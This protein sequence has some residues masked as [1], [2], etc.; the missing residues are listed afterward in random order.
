LTIYTYKMAQPLKLDI[1]SLIETNPITKLS[2]DYN[3]KLLTKIK[4]NFTDME[5]QLFLSSFYCYL[6]YHPTND[7]I[8]DLDN[9]WKWLGFNKK[10]NSERILEKHFKIDIDYKIL[11]PQVGEASLW[12]GHNK[13]TVLLTIHTF[14]LFCLLAETQKAKELHS[15]FIKLEELLHEVLEEEAKELKA[16]LLCIEQ[17]KLYEKQKAVEQTLI[18]QFPLNTECVYFGK[19]DNTNETNELLIK[20]G[21]TNNLSNRILEHRKNYDNFILL[22][23]FKVQNKVE[24]ENCI[25]CHP[26]IKKQLRNIQV[27]GKNKTEIIAYNNGNFTIDKLTKYIKEIIQEKMYS[28][29]NYNNL[30]KQNKELLS[31][32]DE[33]KNQLKKYNETIVKQTLEINELNEKLELQKNQLQ[34]FEIENQS[35]YQN[36]LL[37]EDEQTN[38]FNEFIDTMCI[39]HSEVE[40]SS[41]NMEG[42]Y[43]IWNKIKPTK[44]IF[45]AFKNYLDVRFKSSRLSTQIKNQVVNGYKGVKLRPI[46]YTK[47]YINNDVE[48]FLFQVCA[49]SPSGK[50]LNTTLL[51]EFQ[52]W[53]QALNKENDENDLKNIKEYLN[54]CEYV[55]KATIWME[56]LSNEG[57]YGISLKK[58]IY[59]HKNTSS[60]GKKVE[61]ID[62]NTGFT[63][64]VWDTIA[65]A[66]EEENISA[67]KMSRSIKNNVIFHNNYYYKIVS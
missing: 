49:F 34:I 47:K 46:E 42:A 40:E 48:T 24:I 31:E 63:L 13:K 54:N 3:V 4:D 18:N 10:Y 1:V 17:D 38:K 33:L 6:N 21:H 20:F 50:I 53:K 28:I 41:T 56:Q 61:K 9:V 55:L 65:K 22:Q 15:Y 64:C 5:Q 60:T 19:I 25:K 27:N 45:H 2:S 23:A 37:P 8:V 39:V 35:V 32:N 16:K 43:R 7:F 66:A 58:D 52:R 26:K 62:C 44:E 11:A 29:D 12:G 59:K 51:S 67:A 57:Y 30:L 36:P 14:K